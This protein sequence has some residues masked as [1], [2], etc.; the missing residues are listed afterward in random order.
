MAKLERGAIRCD[1]CNQVVGAVTKYAGEYQCDECMSALRTQE[2]EESGMSESKAEPKT[3]DKTESAPAPRMEASL[4][5]HVISAT[6][7]MDA[8][9]DNSLR[10]RGPNSEALFGSLYIRPE[11]RPGMVIGAKV[12]VTVEFE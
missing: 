11:V 7:E 2:Q 9:K 10:L 5:Q 8:T 12:K 3:K 6:F 1:V 4:G